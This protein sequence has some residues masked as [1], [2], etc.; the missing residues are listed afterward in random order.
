MIDDR[1][2][3][4]EAEQLLAL[5][6]NPKVSKRALERAFELAFPE[7]DQSQWQ[8]FLLR[9]FYSLGGALFVCG[10]FFFVDHFW[11]DLNYPMRVG[12]FVLATAVTALAAWRRGVKSIA[13]KVALTCTSVLW[14]GLLITAS[15]VYQ[16]GQWHTVLTAWSAVCLPLAILAEFAPLWLFATGLFN[17]TLS[18]L[19]HQFFDDT[20]FHRH[21]YEI[22]ILALNLV[23]LASWEIGFQQGRRWM[24]RRWFPPLLTIAGLGPLTLATAGLITAHRYGTLLYPVGPVVLLAW[25]GLLSY[26]SAI[27]RDVSVLSL[28]LGSAVITGTSLLWTFLSYSNEPASL[29]VLSAGIALQI[30][31]SLGAL[32]KLAPALPVDSGKEAQ[33]RT[34]IKAW[35]GQLATEGLIET[36]QLEE[37]GKSIQVQHESAL[38]W[39]VRALT[40]FGAFVSSIFLLLYL[41]LTETVTQQNGVVFGIVMC[42]FA[43]LAARVKS[44]LLQQSAL[45]VS[46]CGQILVWLIMVLNKHEPSQ[47]YATMVAL[48]LGLVVYYPHAFGRFVSFNAAGLFGATWLTYTFH[49]MALDIYVAI[50]AALAA[51]LWL[52]QPVIFSGPLGRIHGPVALASV[53]LLFMLL[54]STLSHGGRVPEVGTV[55]ALCLAALTLYAARF[56]GAPQN[57]LIGLGLVGLICYSAPGVMAAILVLLLGY[58][59]RNQTLQG[60][61]ILFLVAFGAAFYYHLTFTLLNKSVILMASGLVLAVTARNL[62]SYRPKF[63]LPDPPDY[64][65]VD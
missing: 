58:Y 23:L 62:E 47:I 53:S 17:A 29:F 45:S 60:T 19:C 24:G 44:D 11:D 7:P 25:A 56:I 63:K 48:E 27:R 50:V 22:A 49:P 31:A 51:V 13:G 36:R 41:I 37:L 12:F 65:S 3:Q 4:I 18:S 57:A 35:L 32:R 30:S 10:L 52:Q 59:R 61:A 28:T 38:P 42:V 40:G 8:L 1:F 43:C 5:Q 21:Y 16:T 6:E 33:E 14:G 54:F 55:A 20:F 39:F 2:V 26:Y 9:L 34:T 46:I 64:E 15:E